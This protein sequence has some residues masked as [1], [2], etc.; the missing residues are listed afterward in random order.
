MKNDFKH[1]TS[2]MSDIKHDDIVIDMNDFHEF[3]EEGIKKM[4]QLI[5]IYREWK[6]QVYDNI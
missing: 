3:N 4:G 2:F 6:Q 5:Q 1:V